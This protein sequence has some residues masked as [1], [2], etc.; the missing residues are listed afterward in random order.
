MQTHAEAFAGKT[1]SDIT[2]RSFNKPLLRWTNPQ[3]NIQDGILA[4]WV[5]ESGVPLAAAQICLTP[6]STTQWAIEFQSL[7]TDTLTLSNEEIVWSPSKPGIQWTPYDDVGVPSLRPNRRL[8]QMRTLARKFRGDDNFENEESVLRLQTNPLIR[9]ANPE[10]GIVDGALFALVHGTDPELLIMIEAKQESEKL[11]FRYALAPMTS[12]ELRAY[13]DRKEVWH[14]PIMTSN[15]PSDIFHQRLLVA[16]NES[17][18]RSM[19]ME[20]KGFL[21]L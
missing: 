17:N 14:K 7:S 12:F 2:I 5:D 18:E 10:G 13:L 1:A 16:G 11:T 20:L 3:T 9:Y 8:V 19:L 21:G 15:Q 4:C 6:N